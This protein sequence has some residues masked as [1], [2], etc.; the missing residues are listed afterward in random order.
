MRVTYHSYLRP[1]HAHDKHG[2][3]YI[4]ATGETPKIGLHL[5]ANNPEYCLHFPI[6]AWLAKALFL[7]C[8]S[9]H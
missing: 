4:R 7:Q 2:T 9:W 3:V 8:Q 5:L 6:L 1:K